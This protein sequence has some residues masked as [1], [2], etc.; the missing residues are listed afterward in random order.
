[1][2]MIIS[3]MNPVLGLGDVEFLRD[4]R[5]G[6]AGYEHH[7]ALEE[8]A[9]RGERPDPPL[10]GRHGRPQQRRP[11]R[12]GRGFVDIGLDR[13]LAWRR[14]FGRGRNVDTHD[15][16]PPTRACRCNAI[17]A[18]APE[19]WAASVSLSTDKLHADDI[20]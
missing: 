14:S 16:E 7:E 8:F 15:V 17:P 2:K 6:D 1:M 5:Q 11:V 9:G 13:S 20:D 12:P 19:G 3:T 4:Q 18:R 10:H